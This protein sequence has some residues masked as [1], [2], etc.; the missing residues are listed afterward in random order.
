M[1]YLRF[2]LILVCF[3]INALACDDILRD[4]NGKEVKFGSE[5]YNNLWVDSTSLILWVRVES[6][7]KNGKNQAEYR[8]LVKEVLKGTFRGSY[9]SMDTF[10]FPPNIAKDEI[11]QKDKIVIGRFDKRSD[12]TFD[13]PYGF[14]G[15]SY[16]LFLG[17]EFDKMFEQVEDTNNIWIRFIRNRVKG[18]NKI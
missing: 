2:F 13:K 17:V 16:V 12:C 1:M 8:F 18:I 14:Q 11:Y 6:I 7:V 5:A 10:M 9:L 4:K 3:S 15:K